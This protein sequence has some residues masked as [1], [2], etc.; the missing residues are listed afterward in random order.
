[1]WSEARGVPAL[2]VGRAVAPT[3]Y[4]T[5]IPFETARDYLLQLPGLPAEVATQLRAFSADGTTL[6]LP[7]GD[8][9]GSV[10]TSDADVNGVPATVIELRDGSMAGV[11]WVDDGVV[12]VVAGLLS[13]D[14]V[15]DVARG[16]E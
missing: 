14:E 16:F 10:V 5:G 13:V 6:P 11:V 7:I 2:V 9:D 15:L 12:T 3:G 8:P 1:V 4:S